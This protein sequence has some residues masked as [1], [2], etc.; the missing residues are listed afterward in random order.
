MAGRFFDGQVRSE[1]GFGVMG[2]SSGANTALLMAS[3][4]PAIGIQADPRVQAILLLGIVAGMDPSRLPYVT[5]P[6]LFSVGT[7]DLVAPPATTAW[8]FDGI[9]SSPRL[10][11]ELSGAAHKPAGGRATRDAHALLRHP[12]RDLLSNDRGRRVHTALAG[13][14]SQ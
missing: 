3:G 5:V 9:A 1:R 13:G 6:A 11:V 2:L 14:R 10:M 7:A 4:F 12:R 8:Y